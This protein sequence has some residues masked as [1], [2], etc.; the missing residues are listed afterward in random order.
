MDPDTTWNQIRQ[1][2]TGARI[3]IVSNRD[4]KPLQQTLEKL[5]GARVTWVIARPRKIESLVQSIRLGKYTFVIC[6]TGWMN[7]KTDMVLSRACLHS[8][9]VYVRGD[10][11]RPNAVMLALSRDLGVG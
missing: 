5:L 11:G 4:D 1:R 3:V 7:H 6:F 10:K 2:T 8:E 9:T